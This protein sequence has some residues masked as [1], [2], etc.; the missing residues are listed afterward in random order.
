MIIL[1]SNYLYQC[2][3]IIIYI[4]AN[5]NLESMHPFSF[6]THSSHGMHKIKLICEIKIGPN[7]WVF[8]LEVNWTSQ[9][10]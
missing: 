4:N 8:L 10:A 6:T 2:L 9:I 5:I 1:I 7:T 3:S